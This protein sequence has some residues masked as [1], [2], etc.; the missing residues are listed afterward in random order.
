MKYTS[1]FFVRRSTLTAD[2]ATRILELLWPALHPDSVLDV[3]CATGLWLA[4][5]KRRGA[6]KILGVDGPWVPKQKLEIARE[7]FLETDLNRALP[8]DLGQF[9][10]AL[11]I[12]VAE[13]LN[14]T[15]GDK[16]IDFLTAHA[17]AVLFSAAVPGQ[18][19]TGHTNE[20]LQSYWYEK[21]SSRGFTCFD[22]VRENVWE[23]DKVNVI[24]KQ[25]MLLY[26]QTGT[27][28]YN[29]IN[30]TEPH[31]AQVSSPFELNRIHPELFLERSMKNMPGAMEKAIRKLWGSITRRK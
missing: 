8:S 12:E 9:D 21:F 28:A 5:C 3:G 27:T 24:Y 19:G 11:C 29:E 14:P 26:V 30:S 18:R 31:V 16:V 1:D 20:Q 25:N 15:S 2:S 4:E 10:L 6:S 17:D 7:D 23:E 13:H 22:A